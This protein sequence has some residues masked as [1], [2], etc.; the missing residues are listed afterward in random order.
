MPVPPRAGPAPAVLAGVSLWRLLI[1]ASALTGFLLAVGGSGSFAGAFAGLSQQAS[2]LTAVVYLGL[3]CYPVLAGL[4]RH[5]PRSPWL[6]GAVAVLLSLVGGTFLTLMGGSLDEGWSLFEHL[7]TPLL[8]LVDWIAVGRNQ[9][10]CRWWHPPTWLVFPLAYL[11][12][13]NLAAVGIYDFPLEFGDTGF[14][15]S[16]AGF[17]AAVLAAGYL[18]Y[19]IGRIR[20]LAVPPA[21]PIGPPAPAGYPPQP[22]PPQ[23]FPPPGQHFGPSGRP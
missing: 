5:E 12:Y 3:L 18:L 6:R 8:V 10:N 21:T 14:A 23:G 2:L 1:V 20:A 15:G 17:L 13:Y 11:V 7:I 22:F 9:M 16:L 19:G 4:R